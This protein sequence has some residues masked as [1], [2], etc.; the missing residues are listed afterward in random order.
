MQTIIN[1]GYKFKIVPTKDQK[2]FFMQSFG[3][4]RKIYNLYVAE[5]Y[6]QLENIDYQNGYIKRNRLHLSNY[7]DFKKQYDYMRLVDAQCL[8]SAKT[9]FNNA[10]AKFNNKY[11]KKTYTKRSRKREKTLGIAPTFKD[12]KG[13]PRFKS[14]KNNDFSYRTYNQSM[15]E[16]WNLITLKDKQL[17]IP[18]L[19]SLIKVKQ[20]RPLPKDS[21][22]KNC[23]ISMDNKG[24][25]YASLCV[26][27]TIDI[28]LKKSEKILGLDYSQHD[29]YVDSNGEKANYPH[30]YKKSQK[31]LAKLQ[32]EL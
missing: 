18:K 22:I 4:A 13:M 6:V 10:I 26:E 15:G 23:T 11:D 28:E 12:L 20:H 5:L 24:V 1:R 30:Y 9:D 16:K 31:K 32:R 19:K 21:I 7:A 25:F 17:K 29:F 14:I 27:Y 3:C 8:S 2:E